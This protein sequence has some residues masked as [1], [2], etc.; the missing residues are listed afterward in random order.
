[1]YGFQYYTF[2]LN[3]GADELL[4]VYQGQVRRLRVRCFEGLV[5]DLDAT[6]LK[7]FTTSSGIAGT[8]RLVTDADHR[9]VRLERI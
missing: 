6:H 2:S 4:R 8:F 7:Q 1:M 3:I 5:V 9:F